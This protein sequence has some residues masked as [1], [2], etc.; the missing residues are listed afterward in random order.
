MEGVL[1]FNPIRIDKG[2]ED[3]I[4]VGSD[5]QT[6]KINHGGDI[7]GTVMCPFPGVA[8][9]G[10]V[11]SDSWIGSWVD[12]NLRKAYMGAFPLG[13]EW[14]S[15][16]LE[17][18]NLNNAD[19]DQSIGK[20][21]TWTRELQSEPVAMCSVEENIVFACL[22]SGIY[23]ID[24]NASEIWR[25]PYPRWRELEDLVG[26]D[27]IV[28]IVRR[29]DEVYVFSSSGGYSAIS[30]VTGHEMDNGIL[31]NLPEKIHDVRFDQDSGWIIMLNGKKLA[32]LDDLVS[33]PVIFKVPGPVMDAFPH[34]GGWMW[35]GWRHDGFL[36]NDKLSIFQRSEVGVSLLGD[37]VLTNSG[38]WSRLFGDGTLPDEK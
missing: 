33:K 34:G 2:I 7:N 15:T 16:G 36:S 35:T 26:L 19:S 32:I 38:S 4:V 27:S 31:Q 23:M 28:S 20:S 9:C 18:D 13:G 5:G 1:G 14:D 6:V 30:I 22:G 24:R 29:E 21:A 8:S 11:T 12:R 17:S 10:V 37:K 25:S 3:C